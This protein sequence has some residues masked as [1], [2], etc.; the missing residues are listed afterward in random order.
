MYWASWHRSRP[1]VHDRWRISAQGWRRV[2]F[3]STLFHECSHATINPSR[4]NR[5]NERTKDGYATEELVA[6]LSSVFVCAA[7]GYSYNAAQSP[8]Y[9][10]GWLKVLKADSRAIVSISSQ[11]SKVADW[12]LQNGHGADE[13]R[14]EHEQPKVDNAI[15]Y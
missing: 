13:T 1:A 7:L 3:A 4:L 12:M 11:A 15:P 10:G 9:I 6:E 8:A 5:K 2:D 14:P